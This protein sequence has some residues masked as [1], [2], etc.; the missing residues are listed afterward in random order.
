MTMAAASFGEVRTALSVGK[1]AEEFGVTPATVRNWVEKGYIQ[2]LR[3]PS[4][5]RRIPDSEIKRVLR[6][7]FVLAPA[8]PED[9]AQV[10]RFG[11]ATPDWEEPAV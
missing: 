2:A 6:E 8:E 11:A 5:V 3:L 1:A 4:G 9:E 10:A 7:M